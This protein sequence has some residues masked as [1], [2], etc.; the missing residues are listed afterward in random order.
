MNE[1]NNSIKQTKQEI[2][3]HFTGKMNHTTYPKEIYRE[4]RLAQL[5]TAKAG[6]DCKGCRNHCGRSISAGDK[7]YAVRSGS[8]LT[9]KIYPDKI[10]VDCIKPYFDGVVSR[11]EETERAILKEQQEIKARGGRITPCLGV[12]EKAEIISNCVVSWQGQERR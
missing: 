9:G 5:R 7:Y 8:G 6:C 12:T 1:T 3:G 4:G 2:K 11:R 10:P